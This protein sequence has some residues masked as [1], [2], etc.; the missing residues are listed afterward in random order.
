MILKPQQR[1]KLV[2]RQFLHADFHVLRE[3]E[4]QESLLLASKVGPNLHLGSCQHSPAFPAVGLIEDEAVTLPLQPGFVRLVLLQR[5][6][7]FQ[8][9]EPG[10]LLSI[11]QFGR[12]SG[13][14]PEHVIDVSKGLFEH[15]GVS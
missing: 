13:F 14:F 10:G 3:H 7:M 8:E 4:V 2:L 11:V 12:T 15:E 1:R 5:V 9:Q 6:E